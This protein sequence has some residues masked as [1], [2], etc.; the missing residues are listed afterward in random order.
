MELW[1]LYD[2]NRNKLNIDQ[3]RGEKIPNGAYH[4]VTHV[5]IKN[6]KNEY[7]ISK[8]SMKKKYP[9][10][11]ECVGGSVLKDETTY[12][13]SIRETKEEVGV[14]L[15]NSSYKFITSFVRKDIQDIVDVY[16]FNYDG[17]ASLDLATTDEVVEVKWMK[18][19][20]I[21]SLYEDNKLMHTLEY[22]FELD[23]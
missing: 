6:S 17:E 9:L 11:W 10:M 20:E 1:D 19:D 4:L 8:R 16:M 7:L 23:I 13:A 5:W 21:L 15:T 14:D 3:V 18:K 12:L 22:F 2:E